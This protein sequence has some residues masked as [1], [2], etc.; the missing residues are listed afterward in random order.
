MTALV[1]HQPRMDEHDRYKKS[2]LTDTTFTE[3]QPRCLQ[4]R[5]EEKNVVKFNRMKLGSTTY[6]HDQRTIIKLS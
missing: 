3:Y 4:N 6:Q 2:K 5:P 1:I